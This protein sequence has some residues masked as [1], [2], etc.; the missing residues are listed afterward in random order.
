MQCV[1]CGKE[2][3]EGKSHKNRQ[4]YCSRRCGSKN[5]YEKHKEKLR[6]YALNRYHNKMKND[7]LYKIERKKYCKEIWKKIKLSPKLLNEKRENERKK[8]AKVRLECLI[9]YGGN[10]PK[11]SCCREEI[12]EFLTIDH[13]NGGGNEERK[14]LGI[15][16][17][18]FPFYLWLKKNNFPKGYQVLCMN[19][20]WGRRMNNEVCPHVKTRM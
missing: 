4:K 3:Q 6:K 1:V 18:G 16:G 10:P 12:I 15:K 20:N 19:C 2:F 7:P 5:Y 13:V 9:Y 8:I 17:G 14:K 11:C